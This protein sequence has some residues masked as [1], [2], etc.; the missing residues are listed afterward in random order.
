MD[1]SKVTDRARK[2][3]QLAEQEA[4]RFGH[5]SVGT[6]H[7]L[8]GL[9]KEGSGVGAHVLKHFGI[10]LRSIRLAVEDKRPHETDDFSELTMEPSAM[11]VIDNCLKIAKELGHN[12]VGTEHLLLSLL[13][14]S[15]MAKEII[16]DLT[17]DDNRDTMESE[18]IKLLS[19]IK[20]ETPESSNSKQLREIAS[21]LLKHYTGLMNAEQSLREIKKLV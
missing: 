21:V 4:K 2:V 12:Y 5:L 18:V 10:D 15:D 14:S 3:V 16:I 13:R 17:D 1:L 9:A 19:P 20:D 7:L 11:A 6:E 8:L